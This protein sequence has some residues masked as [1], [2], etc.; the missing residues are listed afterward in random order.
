M[1]LHKKHRLSLLF[2]AKLT[3]FMC[4]RHKL[5]L[6]SYFTYEFPSSSNPTSFDI[7]T[8]TKSNTQIENTW[9]L[10]ALMQMR[11]EFANLWLCERVCV[12]LCCRRNS[13]KRSKMQNCL[14]VIT[15]NIVIKQTISCHN[16]RKLLQFPHSQTE[17]KVWCDT[18]KIELGHC[19]QWHVDELNKRQRSPANIIV[20]K[21]K[22]WWRYQHTQR[23]I[24]KQLDIQPFG[25]GVCVCVWLVS[26]SPLVSARNG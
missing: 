7:A 18:K 23:S 19:R 14:N 17:I 10:T 2:R 24:I 3:S 1:L 16:N 5:I 26:N 13:C 25:K 20:N 22:K 15:I 12:C 4:R 8:T 21:T 9:K 6:V 11:R